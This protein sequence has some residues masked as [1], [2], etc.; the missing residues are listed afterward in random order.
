[1]SEIKA[2]EMTE[3]LI[4]AA[5]DYEKAEGMY[6]AGARRELNE[7]RAAVEAALSSLISSR[8]PTREDGK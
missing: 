1:M 8:Q 2:A 3:R 6:V 7:A 4:Q 5:V